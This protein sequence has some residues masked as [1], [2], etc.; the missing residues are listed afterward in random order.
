LITEAICSAALLEI[1]QTTNTLTNDNEIYTKEFLNVYSQQI[2]RK[3][4]KMQEPNNE[5][6]KPT[7]TAHL[8][9]PP[10]K[11]VIVVLNINT[12]LWL[13]FPLYVEPVEMG[14]ALNQQQVHH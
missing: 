14:F 4:L 8:N 3:G 13:G 2:F 7:F 10:I 9:N 1:I 5:E 11:Y 6:V 12:L